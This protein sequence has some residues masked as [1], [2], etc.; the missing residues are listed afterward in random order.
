MKKMTKGMLMTALICGAV[1]LGGSP[2]YASELQEFSLDEYV[3][4]AA[5]METKLV[6]T[7]ANISVVDAQTIEERHYQDV[8]E[9]LKDVPG[10]TVLDTGVGTSE[11]VVRLNGDERVLLLIDGRRVSTDMGLTN[12]NRATVDMNL[13][14][15]V[16][17]IERIEVLK[18][19]GGSLYGS[20]AVGGVINI[21]TKKIDSNNGKVAV[22]FG[23]NGTEDLK[24]NYSIKT[25]KTSVLISASK[26]KQDYYKFR[27]AATDTTKR[28][29][30]DSNYK[31]EKVSLK[32]EQEL[33][34][35]SSIT[36]GYD[37]TKLEGMSNMSYAYAG[38][39]YDKQTDNIYIKYDW[40]VN[41]KDDGFV[42]YYH[43]Q[44]E[45]NNFGRMEE[46]TNGIDI[47]QSITL[48]EENKLV[49]GASWRE[50]EAFNSY[51]DWTGTLVQ[52]Y[53]D[54][55]D[56]IAIFLNDTWE[57][58]PTW[59]LNVGVR[60]DDHNKAGEET[61]LSAG[62]NKKFNDNSHAYF[63]WGQVFKAPSTD[64][65]YYTGGS[66]PGW[67]LYGDPNLK[68]ETGET[69]TIGYT[70]KFNDKTEVGINYFES[71][72]DDAIY[73]DY[74]DTHRV[75]NLHKQEKR[76]L[77][78]TLTQN[79]NDN[80][81]LTASYT[82]LKMKNDR[83]DGNGLVRDYNAVPNIYRLGIKYKDGKWNSNVWLRAGSGAETN[84]GTKYVDSKYL[85]VDMSITYQ[86]TKDLSF[87]AKGY[88]LF[89]EAYADYA[90]ASNG[91]YNTP[92]QSR[93]FIVGAEY[94][95]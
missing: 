23:S 84:S 77:E 38:T 14:P 19:A 94:K 58:V 24:A 64:D 69:W 4:T 62:I 18:G 65:L 37:Y 90:G 50:T 28:W 22:G 20:E 25:D 41:G 53:D 57:F 79:I 43:N 39:E 87:Y 80:L 83:A 70:T 49:V 36:V 71:N 46:K 45:Y 44:L 5:R 29:A 72:L 93:R 68:P 31:N 86:A 67:E 7:P 8:S 2:V 95:F 17:L 1:Y 10:A 9:V 30:G 13:L 91:S 52:N 42:Q 21:I 12:S 85:T 81:A 11:K 3:V 59:T 48:S 61:T 55:I 63:N 60:Y 26:Y 76:G 82:Y 54:K 35:V 33:N 88:N 16:D 40:V 27:D 78:A 92:A 6:D 51:T 56:N 47:Q 73:W 66:M 32:L 89:N 34:E 74:M 15:D 75:L